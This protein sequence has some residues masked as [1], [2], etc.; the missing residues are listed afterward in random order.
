MVKWNKKTFELW[1]DRI[2]GMNLEYPHAF[3]HKKLE[4]A[5]SS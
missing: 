2:I 5:S 1:R 4:M 3:F